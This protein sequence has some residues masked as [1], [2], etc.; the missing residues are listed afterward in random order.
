MTH[1]T[2]KMMINFLSLLVLDDVLFK[3]WS[4][5]PT[6]VL[7]PFLNMLNVEVD[8]LFLQKLEYEMYHTDYPVD[9]IFLK[10]DIV[11]TL[12]PLTQI[13]NFSNP[14]IYYFHIFFNNNIHSLMIHSE[15]KGHN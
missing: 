8:R 4:K 15:T 14:G 2:E 7:R 9:Y 10:L 11:V 12:T 6:C 3:N 13:F 1:L 5:I